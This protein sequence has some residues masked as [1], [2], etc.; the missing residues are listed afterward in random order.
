MIKPPKSDF[1]TSHLIFNPSRS[2]LLC[3]LKVD[4]IFNLSKIDP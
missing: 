4:P 1:L 2:G 3:K